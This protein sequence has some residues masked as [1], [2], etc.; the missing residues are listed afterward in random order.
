MTFNRAILRAAAMSVA[1][2]AVVGIQLAAAEDKPKSPDPKFDKLDKNRDGYV[3]RDE[4]RSLRDYGKAF[5]QADENKDGKLDRGEFVKAEA[6]HDRIVTG[7]YVDDSLVTAKVKAAL[8]REPELNSMDVSVETQAGQVMLS[9]F[10]Q[11]D[12]QRQKAIKT[13]SAVS[14]VASVKDAMQV[15]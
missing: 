2:A 11:D 9:G 5:D 8:L 7:K 14:G 13:A 6:V 4:V 12:K 10:V 1:V 15:K 3:S